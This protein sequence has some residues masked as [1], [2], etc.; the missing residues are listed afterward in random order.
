MEERRR[1]AVQ[2]VREGWT[3]RQ[4]AEFLG[5]SDRAVGAWVAAWRA[6]GDDGLKAR[7]Q[8]GRQPFLTAEP[9]REVLGWLLRPPTEFGFPDELW[10]ARRVAQLIKDRLGVAF[11]PGYLREWL[12][13]RGQSPQRPAERAREG[14]EAAI[15][16]WVEKDWPRL[17]KKRGGAAPTSC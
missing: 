14:D 11:H 2:R 3:Q 16:R 8:P 15:T 1:L 10:T 13:K 9:Q 7:H 12:A 4:V 6:G 5:V 17:K